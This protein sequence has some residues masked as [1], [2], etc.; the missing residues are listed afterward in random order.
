MNQTN[1]RTLTFLTLK[2]K[3][4]I[5]ADG[6]HLGQICD[7]EIDEKGFY[8]TALLLPKK[9]PLFSSHKHTPYRI[10]ISD[11]TKIGEVILVSTKSSNQ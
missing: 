8:I 6:E 1:T 9:T 7:L 10:P 11:I 4:V 3:A 2:G 5:N